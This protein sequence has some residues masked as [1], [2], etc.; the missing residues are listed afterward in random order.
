[1]QALEHLEEPLR[2]LRVNTYA[3]V[4]HGK[5]PVL[6]LLAGGD[7]NTGRTLLAYA[8]SSSIMI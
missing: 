7:M 8:L 3:V 4:A 1:M 2:L 6:A 5:P